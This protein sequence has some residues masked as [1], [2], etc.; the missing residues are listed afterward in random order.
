MA[1]K[2]SIL[3]DYATGTRLCVFYE[4]AV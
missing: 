1:R 4:G 3:K 2:C